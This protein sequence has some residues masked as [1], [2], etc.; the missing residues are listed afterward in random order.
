MGFLDNAK[1]QAANAAAAAKARIE[2]ELQA[3]EDHKRAQAAAAAEPA[4]IRRLLQVI[5]IASLVGLAGCDANSATPTPTGSSVASPRASSTTRNVPRAC[6]LLT[7]ADAQLMMGH[8]TNSVPAIDTYGDGTSQVNSCR[9]EQ[10]DQIHNGWGYVQLTVIGPPTS[11]FINSQLYPGGRSA[12]AWMV[13]TTVTGA[14]RAWI[15][16][17]G[18]GVPSGSTTSSEFMLQKGTNV[19][20]LDDHV[21]GY[22]A[23][24]IVNFMTRIAAG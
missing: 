17:Q 13:P 21:Y 24:E 15:G 10:S 14:D 20:S 12:G 16:F 11:N 23:Q 6:L 4:R 19:Y 8:P 3:R 7:Q 1:E 9:R 22:Q 5:S 2:Q 18:P